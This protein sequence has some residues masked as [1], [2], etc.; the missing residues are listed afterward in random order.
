[1]TSLLAFIP[2]PSSSFLLLSFL[3][4]PPL[5][6]PLPLPPQDIEVVMLGDLERL[7]AIIKDLDNTIAQPSVLPEASRKFVEVS[8]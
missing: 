4:L 5:L 7:Q 2:L 8:Q 6:L 1:M 3:L